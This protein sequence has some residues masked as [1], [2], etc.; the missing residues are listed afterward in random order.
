MKFML[1]HGDDCCRSASACF[2]RELGGKK[3]RKL[4]TCYA[5]VHFAGI[6][7]VITIFLYTSWYVYLMLGT[8]VHT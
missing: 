1:G 5:N 4:T 7:R 6:E 3:E 2:V 8:L